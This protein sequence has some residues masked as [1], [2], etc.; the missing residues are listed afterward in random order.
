M[1]L[2]S[3]LLAAFILIASGVYAQGF[4]NRHF[5]S[6]DGL[7]DGFVYYSFQDK[8]GYLW[9]ATTKGLTKFDGQF[10]KTYAISADGSD[11]IYSGADD[12]S[13]KQWFGS[14]GGKIYTYDETADK[15]VKY[16]DSI[17]GSVDRIIASAD[18]QTL[19]FISRGN[20]INVLSQG[21]LRPI[22]FSQIYQVNSALE[23]DKGL[24][25]LATP[26]GLY[27]LNT[28]NG[29]FS[30]IKNGAGDMAQVQL[31]Q[32]SGAKM[33]VASSSKGLLKLQPDKRLTEVQILPADEFSK[34]NN[35]D[36]GAFCINQSENTVYAALRDESF[37]VL[38]LNNGSLESLGPKILK[39][40]PTTWRLTAK[41]TFGF[42]PQAKA[43]IVFAAKNTA[44]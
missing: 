19:Y 21:K 33:L 20:G 23:W 22:P 34:F 2:C 5:T 10:F 13:G 32:H 40:W 29:E 17:T 1:R 7:P 36:I 15:L 11:F 3:F 31:I 4:T 25:L 27:S 37:H 24:L 28:G 8:K 35:K 30:K 6:A 12:A 14:F 26:E 16:K 42:P 9:S 39:R 44:L 41:I 18:A 38:D 43:F